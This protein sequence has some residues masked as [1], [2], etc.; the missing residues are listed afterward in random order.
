[1]TGHL[2][3]RRTAYRYLVTDTTLDLCQNAREQ[4]GPPACGG[5]CS[6]GPYPQ[7]PKVR[8]PLSR[9]LA[10]R[11]AWTCSRLLRLTLIIL[12]LRVTAGDIA[13]T[14]AAHA[15]ALRRRRTL[16]PSRIVPE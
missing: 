14:Q 10:Q 5:L 6:E 1:M 3:R 9:I 13:V 7:A 12:Q 15:S 8:G 11:L 4:R 16:R 2:L